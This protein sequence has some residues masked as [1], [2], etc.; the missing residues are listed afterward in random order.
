MTFDELLDRLFERYTA[1]LD[2][3]A[4]RRAEDRIE[5]DADVEMIGFIDLG[6]DRGDLTDDEVDGALEWVRHDRLR[7]FSQGLAEALEKEKARRATG[8]SFAP[9]GAEMG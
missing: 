1:S 9:M 4:R 5:Q 2:E 8:V 7:K 3:D 6:L